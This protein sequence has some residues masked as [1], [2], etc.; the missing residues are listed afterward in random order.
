MSNTE[1][2]TLLG[3]PT[4]AKNKLGWETVVTLDDMI[5]EK[6]YPCQANLKTNGFSSIKSLY[7]H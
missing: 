3:D 4:K 6:E 2:G 5:E 1:V 7:D